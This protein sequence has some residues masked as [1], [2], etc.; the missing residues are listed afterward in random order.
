[1]R[2]NDG[3]V[4]GIGKTVY[5][6]ICNSITDR[7]IRKAVAAGAH[8]LDELQR[9][10]PVASLCGSCGELADSIIRETRGSRHAEPAIYCPV[11]A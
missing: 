3:Q 9:Q 11:P 7:Q 1:L 5:V 2:W 6:C 8:S 10:L 4:Q